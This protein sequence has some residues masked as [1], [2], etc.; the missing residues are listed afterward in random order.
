MVLNKVGIIFKVKTGEAGN[1]MQLK[2]QSG[3]C[4]YKYTSELLCNNVNLQYLDSSGIHT[5]HL[6]T[7]LE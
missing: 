7:S 4:Y 2:G 5:S 3:Q 1:F 6:I